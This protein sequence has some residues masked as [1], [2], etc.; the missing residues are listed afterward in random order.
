VKE[1]CSESLN[2]NTRAFV[3]LSLLKGTNDHNKTL[4]KVERGCSGLTSVESF[5]K[6]QQLAEKL[7][8]AILHVASEQNIRLSWRLN[9][10]RNS[11]T[12]KLH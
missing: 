9:I 10:L 5:V 7:R 6:L 3:S 2:S 11:W 1:F 4:S 12:V 8:K